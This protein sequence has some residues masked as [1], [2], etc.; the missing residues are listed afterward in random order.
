MTRTGMGNRF[1]TLQG[2]HSLVEAHGIIAAITF[3]GI[4]PTAIM[5]M[6]FLGRH[7]GWAL[8]LH[9][10]LQIL[11]LLLTTVIFILGWFA[12][13]PRR[14]LTNPHHGI[15][16]AIYV[17]VIVQVFSGAL[18]HRS[19]KLRRRLHKPLKLMLHQWLG[20]AIALLG[21]T[22]VA[23]GLTLYGS[24]VFLFVLYTLWCFGLLVLYFVLTWV[25]DR[26]PEDLDGSHGSYVTEEEM[27]QGDG[28][29]EHEGRGWGKLAAVGL[30]GVGL[31]ALWR[32][33]SNRNK[34]RHSVVGTDESG[35]S[36]MYDEKESDTSRRRWGHRILEIGAIGG[37]LAAL[38][39]LFNRRDRDDAS[40]VGPYRPP[41]GGNQNV[42]ADSV[43]RIEEGRPM[44]RPMTPTGDSPGYVRATHPLA[45]PPMTPGEAGRRNSTSSY[46]YY[47]YM[48]GSP[49]R[50]DRRGHGIRN[51]LAGGGTLLGL[52][53]LFKRRRQNKEENRA[54]TL[55]QQRIEEERLARE[56]STRRYTGDGITPPR[57]MRGDGSGSVTSS[58]FSGSVLDDRHRRPGVSS[59]VPVAAVGAAAAGALADRDR[60]RPPGTDPVIE[61]VGGPSDLPTNV[62]PLPPQHME[63]SGSEIYTTASGRNRRRHH[64]R[65]EAA[66]GMAGAALGAAATDATRRRHSGR[67]QNTDSMESPPVSLKVKMHNDGRHVTLRRLTEEEALAQREAGR[68]ENR[69]SGARR[70]RNSSVSSSELGTGAA[71]DRRWRRTEAVEAAQANAAGPSG[72]AAEPPNPYPPP[73]GHGPASAYQQTGAYQQAPIDPRTGQPMSLPLPPPIPGASSGL[74]GPAGSVTSPGTET[75]GATEYANNRRRRRAE[76]AQAK[77]ARE[78]KNAGGSN[79]SFAN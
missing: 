66:A 4:V 52:R 77:L 17:L 65:D 27:V 73:P 53:Q 29:N 56:N 15:G 18:V 54:E 76:R 32:R 45:N 9:I 23:L 41:L 1:F 14:S 44:N 12:V 28:T 64:L 24:P 38:R 55:R 78:Q 43:S 57:R 35:T 10:W 69:A 2:Y 72:Y 21:I 61:N 68:R 39:T 51:A 48:S 46:S 37:G 63:S 74:G 16:L 40:E 42:E 58:D 33:R 11:T 75:S 47:S 13:G 59:A 49:S 62:P 31:A 3:L 34:S 71:A 5:L 7:P 50:R 25:R 30:G 67:T 70:R 8:R 79:V 20:R 22:Q 26:R 36:Y 60:I 19:E 6:R